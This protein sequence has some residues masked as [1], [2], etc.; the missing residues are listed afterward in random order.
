MKGL[1]LFFKKH[2]R[3]TLPLLLVYSVSALY[4][5]PHPFARKALLLFLMD[6]NSIRTSV[7]VNIDVAGAV[8]E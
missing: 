6:N 5:S 7:I 1:G 8:I 4:A 2:K 3:R